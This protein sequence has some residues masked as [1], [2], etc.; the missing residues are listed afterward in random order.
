MLGL[1]YE[2]EFFITTLF[3]F[4]WERS[5]KAK[6]YYHFLKITFQLSLK[7]LFVYSGPSLPRQ[8]KEAH[9]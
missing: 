8:K 5:F 9:A 1:H 4:L 7:N 2:H 3:K 6:I